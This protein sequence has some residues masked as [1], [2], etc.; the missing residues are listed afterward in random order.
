MSQIQ[1]EQINF[2]VSPVMEY[3]DFPLPKGGS[4][5]EG[6]QTNT[7]FT[8]RFE[9]QP[10]EWVEE[11]FYQIVRDYTQ[12]PFKRLIHRLE[13][14]QVDEEYVRIKNTMRVILR[15]K[16]LAPIN[17]LKFHFDIIPRYRNYQL[18]VAVTHCQR[19]QYWHYRNCEK[20]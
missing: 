10:S 6:L 7:G 11:K 16:I 17:L 2:S 5:K 15:W 3:K 19:L 4:K 1:K 18:A 9:E 13:L 14:T 12:G 20:D 8:F